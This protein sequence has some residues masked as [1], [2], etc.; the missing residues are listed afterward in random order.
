MAETFSENENVGIVAGCEGQ[1]SGVVD[2][3]C[4]TEAIGEGNI[5]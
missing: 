5:I 1:S 4:D 3:Y 2:A